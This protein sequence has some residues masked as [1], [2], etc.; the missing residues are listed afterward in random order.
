MT[1]TVILTITNGN[2]GGTTSFQMNNA[3]NNEVVS[4][5]I[6]VTNP[7]WSTTIDSISF[8]ANPLPVTDGQ[9]AS[10]TWAMPATSTDT[11]T[12]LQAACGSM[13]FEVFTNANGADTAPSNS[14][15]VIEYVPGQW[16]LKVDTTLD[17]SL[18]YTQASVT[19]NLFIKITMDD[20]TTI[21]EY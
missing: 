12:G 1:L 9:V 8:S 11:A 2:N 21:T 4:F 16:S 15:A 17:L 10:A 20:Y 14:W 18:I 7:C 5:D 6:R 19:H 3:G 13:T